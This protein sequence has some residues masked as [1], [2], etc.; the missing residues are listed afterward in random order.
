MRGWAVTAA[1]IAGFGKR[2]EEEEREPGTIE[3]YL[4]EVRAFAAWAGA[5]K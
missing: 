5:R 3:K 1:R 2:L 4:R